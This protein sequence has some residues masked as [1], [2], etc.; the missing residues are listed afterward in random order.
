LVD[1]ENSGLYVLCELLGKH[2]PDIEIVA[3]ARN[4]EV[5]HEEIVKHKPDLV[6]LDIKM[7]GGSGFDLL[8][9]FKEIDFD[10]IFVTSYDKYAINAIKF[11]PLDYL[12]KPVDVKEL[13]ASVEKVRK[14]KAQKEAPREWVL[15]L[16]DNLE[17]TSPDKNIAVHHQDKVKL[18]KL[19]DMVC[20]EAEG[21][22]THIFTSDGQKYTSARVLRDFEEFV[23]TRENFIRITRKVIVNLDYVTE[24]SKGEPYILFMKNGKEYELGRRKRT[25]LMGRIR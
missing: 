7:P 9:K 20:F 6:F 15:N 17:G 10:V 16:L 24:Y 18:L 11:S 14:R 19:S 8:R 21:N 13:L 25:E 12:L 3:Q 2:C 23:S 4:I 22:Y 1:D 5:A